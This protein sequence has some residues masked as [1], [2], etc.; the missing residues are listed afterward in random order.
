MLRLG[1][2]FIFIVIC[3]ILWWFYISY[4]CKYSVGNYQNYITLLVSCIYN[5]SYIVSVL[6]DSLSVPEYTKSVKISSLASYFISAKLFNPQIEGITGR[7]AAVIAKVSITISRAELS[8]IC[9][10]DANPMISSLTGTTTATNH[11][12]SAITTIPVTPERY[13]IPT[14]NTAAAVHLAEGIVVHVAMGTEGTS[15]TTAITVPDATIPKVPEASNEAS[16]GVPAS[17][18]ISFEQKC[19]RGIITAGYFDVIALNEPECG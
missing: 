8:L 18:V 6:Q 12:H 13:V 9:L 14:S 7:K 16:E 10:C 15:P 1:L 11:H 19:I 17:A 3:S 5:S 2:I 4:L